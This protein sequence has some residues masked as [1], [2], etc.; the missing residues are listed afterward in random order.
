MVAGQ[1]MRKDDDFHG[2]VQSASMISMIVLVLDVLFWDWDDL[3]GGFKDF[4]GVLDSFRGSWM[5]Y[6][7]GLGWHS[8]GPD[9]GDLDWYP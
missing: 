3:K 2:L 1:E 8:R 4:I 9:T 5:T 7:G 6:L